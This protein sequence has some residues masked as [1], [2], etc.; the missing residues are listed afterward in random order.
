MKHLKYFEN[1]KY[2]KIGDYVK[3]IDARGFLNKLENN[4]IYYIYKDTQILGTNEYTYIQDD[5]KQ[6]GG[7]INDRFVLATPE[8]IEHSKLEKETKK[9]NL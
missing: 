3:C 5:D 2:F 9:Y 8:E 7:Y 4:K 1:N 6:M